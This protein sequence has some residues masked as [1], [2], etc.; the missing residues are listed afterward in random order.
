MGLDVLEEAAG[1][2]RKFSFKRCCGISCGQ[3]QP[4]PESAKERRGTRPSQKISVSPH[5]PLSVTG[6]SFR[7]A[8]QPT[9]DSLAA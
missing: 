5:I 9:E 4:S 1:W 3:S 6:F 8:Q 2:G 7:G